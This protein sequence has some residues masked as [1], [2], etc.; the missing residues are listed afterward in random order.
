MNRKLWN[1]FIETSGFSLD[2]FVL[3]LPDIF[4]IFFNISEFFLLL[5]S[6]FYPNDLKFKI[7]MNFKFFLHVYFFYFPVWNFI[8]SSL[9]IQQLLIL[10]INNQIFRKY[11]RWPF[12]LLNTDY[13][14]QYFQ[15]QL[16]INDIDN[17]FASWSTWDQLLTVRF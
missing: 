3:F 2:L 11:L 12:P 8:E 7:F 1:Y 14:F 4:R 5:M 13:F 17:F 10:I 15:V 16:L 9:Q 6:H